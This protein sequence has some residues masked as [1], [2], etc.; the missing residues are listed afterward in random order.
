MTT[1]TRLVV[2]SVLATVALLAPS[3]L[4]HAQQGGIA[5]RVGEALDNTGRAIKGGVQNASTRVKNRVTTM[6]VLDRVTSRL[7]WEK[8]LMNSVI[9][10]EVQ[11]GG[12]TVLRGT[13]TDL[14]A[15]AKAIELARD[16]VGVAQVVTELSVAVTEPAASAPVV[17]VPRTTAVPIR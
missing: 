16:T 5:E 1:Q 9:E 10:V 6:E 12:I 8:K 15:K 17:D 3:T 11:P 7:H 14:K 2:A 13:V 4:A